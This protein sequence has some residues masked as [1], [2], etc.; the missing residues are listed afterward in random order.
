MATKKIRKV[1]SR[2]IKSRKNKSRSRKIKR[3]GSEQ[4]QSRYSN[5]LIAK[6]KYIEKILSEKS[7]N[8]HIQKLLSE[9]DKISSALG[10]LTNDE[11]LEDCYATLLSISGRFRILNHNTKNPD[12]KKRI[13]DLLNLH[14]QYFDSTT[15]DEIDELLNDMYETDPEHSTLSTVSS[16][17]SNGL[18]RLSS[19]FSTGYS[20]LSS[21]LS[22]VSQLPQSIGFGSKSLNDSMIH[23]LQDNKIDL[24]QI[25]SSLTKVIENTEHP[26][27]KPTFVYIIDKINFLIKKLYTQKDISEK[28]IDEMNEAYH[29]VFGTRETSSELSIDDKMNKLIEYIKIIIKKYQ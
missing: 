24:N 10:Y 13:L 27:Y 25:V 5:I 19:G 4:A 16:G 21:G 14:I 12:K 11:K 22:T 1:K 3:G 29:D 7:K 9:Y 20:T 8:E 18:S 15:S 28:D 2:K 6:I 23:K 26:Q 17:I